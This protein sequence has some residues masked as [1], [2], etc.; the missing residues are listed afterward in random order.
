MRVTVIGTGYVGLVSGACFADIGHFVTCVDINPNKVAMLNNGGCPIYEPGLTEILKR[1]RESGRLTFSTELNSAVE[2]DC[3]FLAVQT[4]SGDSGEANLTYLLDAAR[5]IAPL[6]KNNCVVVIKSTVP[7]GTGEKVREILK[8]STN[9][10]FFVVNNPEFLKEGAAIEDFMRPD[11]IVI[12]ADAPEAVEVMENLYRP[13]TE[14]GSPLFSM[15]NVSAEMTKY[16]ANCFLATKISF[17]NEIAR[18]C[19]ATGAN[20]DEVKEGIGTDRRIGPHFLNPGPGYG[21]SCFP[22]DVQALLHTGRK[23]GVELKMVQAA[24]EVNGDQK[25]YILSMILKHYSNVAGKTFAVW[26]AAFKAN[27]DD[28]R[29]SPVIDLAQGL[30]KAGAIIK[31]YDPEASANFLTQVSGKNLHAVSNAMDCLE[32]ADALVI[33]TEWNE[34]KNPNYPQLAKKLKDRIVFD[35]RNLLNALELE[36]V[37]LSYYSIGRGQS[38]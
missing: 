20:I 37:G 35:A 2:S 29:E 30:L 5:N 34:F 33:M 9:K 17:I 36:K 26:G 25:R 21:G 7:V 4:P 22:K 19:D 13:L 15:S 3:L 27:T 38:V 31:F 28:V 18:L 6:I 12:G 10:N 14:Q 23:H 8:S 1:N 16:A 32:G 24:E 11:R